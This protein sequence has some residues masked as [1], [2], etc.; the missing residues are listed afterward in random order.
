MVPIFY[1]RFYTPN[2]NYEAV[3]S[4]YVETEETFLFEL[5][6]ENNLLMYQKRWCVII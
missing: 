2:G 5:Y 3:A 6:G 4:I 1:M